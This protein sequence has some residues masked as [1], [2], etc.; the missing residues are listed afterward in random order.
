MTF[1][2]MWETFHQQLLSYIRSQINNQHDAE[3]ILQLVFIKVYEKVDQLKKPEATKSWLYTI[4][5]NTIIDYYKKQRDIAVAP[6]TFY[7]LV[8]P[9]IDQDNMNEEMVVCLE[10]MC[11]QLPDKYQTVYDLYEKEGLKHQEIADHLD[12]S[13]S[14]SKARLSRAK[15][16]FKDLMLKCCD[17]EVDTYGNIIDYKSKKNK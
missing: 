14:T 15:K 6:E 4:T 13:L 17:F 7:D 16:M 8:S 12:I 5:R 10:R 11:F 2:T 9:E 3:D 1:E